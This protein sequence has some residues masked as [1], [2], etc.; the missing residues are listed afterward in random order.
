M[1]QRSTYSPASSAV[2]KAADVGGESCMLRTLSGESLVCPHDTLAWASVTSAEDG[3]DASRDWT[4]EPDSLDGR[5]V[6]PWGFE[7]GGRDERGIDEGGRDAGLDD[8]PVGDCGVSGRLE[9]RSTASTEAR[10]AV[11][12][13]RT[14]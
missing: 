6:R 1:T 10:P 12:W 5:G 13:L 8:E 9:S 2:E 7:E 14:I 4:P 11:R 3:R